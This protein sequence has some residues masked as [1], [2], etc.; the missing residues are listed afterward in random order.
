MIRHH[1]SAV[2]LLR[3]EAGRLPPLH[4]R[5]LEAH[6]GQCEDCRAALR[7]A[8]A[9]AGALL[10]SLDPV[11]LAPDAWPNTL[12]R[13]SQ[14]LDAAPALPGAADALAAAN[15]KPWRRIAPGITTT[16]LAAR[17]ATGTRLDLLRVAPGASLLSHGHTGLETLCVLQG[18]YEDGIETYAAGDFA[19]ADGSIDHR[20]VAL[21]GAD[22]IC[23]F[24]TTGRLTPHSL[25]GRLIRPFLGM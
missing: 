3:H 22:C 21:P 19:E 11:P 2:L 23:L 20:P 8:E 15:G 16:A 18:M 24:A 7:D 6:L 9:V 1:P 4:A 25:V 17:D 13:L 10:A 14:P 5:V 12:A